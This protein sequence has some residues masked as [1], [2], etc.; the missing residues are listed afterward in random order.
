V[1]YFSVIKR[2]EREA[3]QSLP[4]ITKGKNK[5]SYIS[6]PPVYLYGVAKYNFN[7]FLI[8]TYNLN[9]GSVSNGEA[10]SVYV[11]EMSVVSKVVFPMHAMKMYRGVK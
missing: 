11:I 10:R 8:F 5:W 4:P 6:T 3:D 1:A 2:P 9:P 7:F